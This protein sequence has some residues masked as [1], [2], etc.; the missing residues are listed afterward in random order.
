MMQCGDR[1]M[2]VSQGMN[3]STVYCT[4]I[5]DFTAYTC[6]QVEMKV[7]FH[8]VVTTLH[9]YASVCVCLCRLLQLLKD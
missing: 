8:G 4:K 9:H 1:L 2:T 3:P 6:T 5:L 7:Y